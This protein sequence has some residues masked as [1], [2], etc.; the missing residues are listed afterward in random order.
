MAKQNFSV[1]NC[2][3]GRIT[4]SGFLKNHTIYTI[5]N[6]HVLVK[7]LNFWRQKLWL[8]YNVFDR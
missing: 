3:S 5:L 6:V 8:G 7:V 1:L 4:H 2:V